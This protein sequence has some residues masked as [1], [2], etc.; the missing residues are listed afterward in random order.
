MEVGATAGTA[1][2]I[3]TPVVG[4]TMGGWAGVPEVEVT[5]P[6]VPR[7]KAVIPAWKGLRVTPEVGV[8]NEASTLV[9]F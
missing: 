7:V 1:G 8:K 3:T 9:V 5:V 6:V 4:L 2:E